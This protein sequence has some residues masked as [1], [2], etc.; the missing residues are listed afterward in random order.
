MSKKSRAAADQ[1][2]PRSDSVQRSACFW[3]SSFLP[4]GFLQA[5]KV[6]RQKKKEPKSDFDDPIQCLRM[7]FLVSW[8]PNLWFLPVFFGFC[9]PLGSESWV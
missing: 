7:V 8:A 6:R 3:L 9:G 2:Q 5:P 1:L 4:L